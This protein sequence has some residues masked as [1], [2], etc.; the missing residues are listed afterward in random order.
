MELSQHFFQVN[1]LNLLIKNVTHKNEKL[2]IN[3]NK[4]EPTAINF[5]ILAL[6]SALMMPRAK[7]RG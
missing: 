1:F 2:P 7:R 4:S 5:A 6:L 3:E